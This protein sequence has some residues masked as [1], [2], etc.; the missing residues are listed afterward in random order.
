VELT[1]FGLVLAKPITFISDLS[2]ALICTTLAARLRTVAESQYLRFSYWFFVLLGTSTLL[3]GIAHLLDQYLGTGAHYLAWLVNGISVVI[4]EMGAT[5]LVR[6]R[7][8]QSA[9]LI[10]A[11]LRYVALTYLVLRTGRFLW[12]ALHA[13][14]GFIVV[15]S[16]IHVVHSLRCRDRSYLVV[17]VATAAMLIPAATHAFDVHLGAVIDRNVVSHLLLIPPLYLL[18]FAFEGR[19]PALHQPCRT[20]E[21]AA[22]V[23]GD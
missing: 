23:S 4:A 18:A 8:V 11:V 14:V 12:V 10:L 17:P 1:I 5:S 13:A 3:G 19:Y 15:V 16:T 6:R 21:I 20:S 2:L 22:R 7:G 9:L